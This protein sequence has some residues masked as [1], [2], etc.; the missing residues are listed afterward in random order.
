M[1]VKKRRPIHT[2]TASLLLLIGRDNEINLVHLQNV[3]HIDRPLVGYYKQ[4]V[5]DYDYSSR[6]IC[7]VRHFT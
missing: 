2:F 5:F 3:S 1:L 6:R 7:R 4:Q